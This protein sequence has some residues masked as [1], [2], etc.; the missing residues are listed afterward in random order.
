MSLR[1][2][3]E[4]GRFAV[5]SEISPPKGV[6]VAE[7]LEMAELVSDRVDAV[8]V[9]D[10]QS[11][12]MRMSSLTACAVLGRHGFKPVLQMTCRDRNRLGIQADLLG[13]AALGI[14]EVLALTGDHPLAGDHPQARGV[15]DLESVQLLDTIRT[16]NSG[17]DMVG[18]EL[19]G[20]TSFYPGAVVTPEADPFEPQMMKFEKKVR[21]GA[22]FFQT[23]AVYDVE[24]FKRFMER[25]RQH[26][27]K[28]L[29]GVLLLRTAGM[30]KYLNAR[31]P[32]VRVPQQL[33][34]RM[35]ASDKP[36][37]TG[38]EIAGE[39]IQAIRD[40]CDGVHVMAVGQE[41]RVPDV[42]DA[43]GIGP[44]VAPIEAVSG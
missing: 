43:A 14:T 13:A 8:N 10:N 1:A 40:E 34:D 16:L 35:A 31:V 37:D 32:G 24:A 23:Q 22:R 11:A 33:I 44:R 39:F 29:A 4:S 7:M 2:I 20:A 19:S 26:D 27:V 6:D 15:F 38:V 30:A 42:L 5:T 3:L 12:V 18:N 9:T 28:I 17:R 21:A 25:A 36:S 41:S